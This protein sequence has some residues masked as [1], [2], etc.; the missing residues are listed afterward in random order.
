MTL[1]RQYATTCDLPDFDDPLVASTMREI[2]PDADPAQPHR[3]WWEFTMGALFLSDVG[4]LDGS[5]AIL[6]VGAGYD[7]ILFWL[8]QRAQ[9]VVATDIYGRGDFAANEAEASFLHDPSALAPYDYPRERLE[10]LDMDARTLDFPDATF[11]AVVSFGSIEHFGSPDQ[12]ARSAREIGR[13]LRPGGHAFIV[14]EV[15]IDLHPADRLIDG[16]ISR[17]GV[18]P[19][20][21]RAQRGLRP[22]G[23]IF[24]APELA[25][26][27][28]AP[29]GLTL[30]QPLRVH[31][32]EPA[33]RNVHRINPDGSTTTTTG[34]PYPH[35]VV[36]AH[37][38]RFTSVCLPLAKPA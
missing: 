14:T 1:S 23:D 21:A 5:A 22:L 4:A 37:W 31:V 13:V 32:G 9:R 33:R 3:K 8:A 12:I 27:I 17:F 15:F 35:I 30:M 34:D 26:V 28:V 7:Q 10:V 6:D 16:A 19:L 11:D 18:G 2:W 36:A 25:R 29:S 38:S 24:T 20:R